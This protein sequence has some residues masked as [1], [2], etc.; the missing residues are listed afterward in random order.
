MF[1]LKCFLLITCFIIACCT[2]SSAIA[3]QTT[4][5]P[6]AEEQIQD[7]E[8][9]KARL[10]AQESA[11]ETLNRRVSGAESAAEKAA[12]T[13]EASTRYADTV[14]KFA[15]GLVSVAVAVLLLFAYYSLRDTRRLRNEAAQ[16]QKAVSR[17]EQAVTR[18]QKAAADSQQTAVRA[19][20][21]TAECASNARQLL[22]ETQEKSKRA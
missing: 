9:L 14:V 10:D 6:A 3:Q 15:G 4:P 11:I 16:S 13:G 5:A 20:Q 2:V 22:L 18:S 8:E 12:A 19:Q 7:T 1:R 21:V 17:S